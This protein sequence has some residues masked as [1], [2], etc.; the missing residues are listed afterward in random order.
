ITMSTDANSDYLDVT[1]FGFNIPS[2]ATITGVYVDVN[3]Y[4][5]STGDNSCFG[6]KDIQLIKSGVAQGTKHASNGGFEYS[7]TG[8][9]DNYYG[10]STDTWGLGLTGA[11]VSASNFGLSI[12]GYSYIISGYNDSGYVTFVKMTVYYT[13]PP[14]TTYDSGT[15]T[16]T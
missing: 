11:D 5:V 1:N 7:D 6:D 2:N 12:Q 4:S 10:S 15:V 13:V 8:P 9:F 3:D 16:V 14:V